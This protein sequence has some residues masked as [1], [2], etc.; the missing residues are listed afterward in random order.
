MSFILTN[1]T[2]ILFE[3]VHSGLLAKKHNKNKL[4]QNKNIANFSQISKL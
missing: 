2:I 3:T 1:L 4:M